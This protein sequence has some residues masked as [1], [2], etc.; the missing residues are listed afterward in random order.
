[1]QDTVQTVLVIEDED[2]VR[3]LLR[4]LLRLAG[5]EVLA[6]QGGDEAVDLMDARGG[7]I[8]LLI[9]D[10]NLGIGMDGF[11]AAER[12]RARQPMLKALFISGEEEADWPARHAS[13]PSDRFLLKPFT[14]RAFGDAVR[15]LLLTV[16]ANAVS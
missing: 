3:N 9:T 15:A 12:L 4:T 13:G 2:T 8:Q 14:P 10:V 6:C 5:Y 16:K 1:M 11:E 7:T